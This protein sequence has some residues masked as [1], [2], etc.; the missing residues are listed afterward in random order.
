[1]EESINYK[2]NIKKSKWK[3]FKGGIYETIDIVFNSEDGSPLVLYK[4]L[5]DE[6]LWVRSIN[7]FFGIV[8]KEDYN[9]PRFIEYNE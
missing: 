4:S 9:G 3:H 7:E 5:D 2:V 1:M 8:N 6:K